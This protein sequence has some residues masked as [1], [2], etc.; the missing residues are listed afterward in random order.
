MTWQTFKN[1]VYIAAIGFCGAG[2]A[3]Q[4]I[5]AIGGRPMYVDPGVFM[6]M[7]VGNVLLLAGGVWLLVWL[8]ARFVVRFLR[9]QLERAKL[10]SAPA[11]G[12]VGP[13]GTPL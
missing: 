2:I 10:V 3:I 12:I 9:G 8:F 1:H 13:D 6:A 7:L 5:Q 11:S 4:I